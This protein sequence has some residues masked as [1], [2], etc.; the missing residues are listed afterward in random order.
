MSAID[1]TMPADIPDSIV[2]EWKHQDNIG[3][4][5]PPSSFT[6]GGRCGEAIT[7]VGKQ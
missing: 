1:E 7:T 2:A 6:G 3:S 4:C 5:F